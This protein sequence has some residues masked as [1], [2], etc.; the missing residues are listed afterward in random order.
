M[1]TIVKILSHSRPI[2]TNKAKKSQKSAANTGFSKP[3]KNIYK[4]SQPLSRAEKEDLNL[5]PTDENIDSTMK[6]TL[7][8]NNKEKDIYLL[9]D[10]NSARDFNKNMTFKYSSA[11]V[12]NKHSDGNESIFSNSMK[13]AAFRAAE[14]KKRSRL[15]IKKYGDK[16]YIDNPRYEHEF[17][18][19]LHNAALTIQDHWR[20]FLIKKKSL[21]TDD[22]NECMSSLKKKYYRSPDFDHPNNNKSSSRNAQSIPMLDLSQVASKKDF[23]NNHT[24]DGIFSQ[25]SMLDLSTKRLQQLIL[26]SDL[27][28]MLKVREEGIHFKYKKEMTKIQKLMS[29]HKI[30][31]RT[32]NIRELE[33]EKWVDEE[34]KDIDRTKKIYEENKKITEENKKKI[35]EIISDTQLTQDQLKKIIAD[36]VTTPRDGQS[37]RSGFNSSRRLY[38]LGNTNKQVSE[39]TSIQFEI[40]PRIKI[41]NDLSADSIANNQN[42]NYDFDNENNRK[43]SLKEQIAHKILKDKGSK[44]DERGSIASIELIDVYK[45]SFNEAHKS[46]DYEI[47]QEIHRETPDGFIDINNS[48]FISKTPI[49]TEEKEELSPKSIKKSGNRNDGKDQSRSLDMGDSFRKYNNNDESNSNSVSLIRIKSEHNLNEQKERNHYDNDKPKKE[50]TYNSKNFFTENFDDQEMEDA[51]NKIKSN[52]D[53]ENS[54]LETNHPNASNQYD[55]N[56]NFYDES[57]T[58]SY[59]ESGLKDLS[60]DPEKIGKLY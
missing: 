30:S 27:P 5:I 21:N 38:E 58:L 26:N 59:D 6:K 24:Q 36:K 20:T 48:K 19:I 34:R 54:G 43:M 8:E 53:F 17:L 46:Q 23:T 25:E 55:Q 9:E 56:I 42:E 49:L 35:E 22:R 12:S 13:L 28:S 60:N 47:S 40:D 1:S 29:S 52:P 45:R 16:Q 15:F 7:E 37:Y 14:L 50:K 11:P 57:L 41:D 51:I 3:N 39:D 2:L 18:K 33:L 44:H 32:G 10:E 31:P 4:R